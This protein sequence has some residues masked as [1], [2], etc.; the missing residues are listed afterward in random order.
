MSNVILEKLYRVEGDLKVLW[1][2]TE[3]GS[4]IFLQSGRSTHLI[5]RLKGRYPL[6]AI[7]LTQSLSDRSGVA[8]SLASVMAL[9][10]YLQLYPTEA[11]KKVRQILLDLSTI[12]SHIY[13]FYWELLP[14]YLNP[15][16]YEVLTE[17]ELWYYSGFHL[18]QTSDVDLSTD[19][20]VRL[21]RNINQAAQV[22]D[23]LQKC[24]ALLGGKFPVIM[25]QVPGGIANFS[26]PRDSGMK[27]LRNLERCKGFIENLWPEDIKLFLQNIPDATM[28]LEKEL[29]LISFGSL[30]AEKTRSKTSNYSE[31]ILL[32]GKLEPVNELKITESIDNTYYLPINGSGRKQ[33]DS[34]DFN[35]PLARTWIKGARYDGS[36]M[37]TGALSRMMITHL[38]GG[39]L[40]ISDKT[41]QMIDDLELTYEAPNCIASRILAQA[42][43]SRISLKNIF[44][45]LLD[46]DQPS[47]TN[48]RTYFDFSVEGVGIGKV[49]SPGGALMHQVFISDRKIERYR[50]ISPM[51]WNFSPADKSGETGIVETELNSLWQ[52][53]DLSPL[54]VARLLHSYYTQVL[55]GTL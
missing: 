45:N 35:K 27:V 44:R 21:V 14:D 8:H 15:D 30:I 17:E 26:I 11:A 31:G 12:R 13:H 5:S 41:G 1:S 52:T 51:N 29:N 22:L 34:Y 28:V 20:G 4:E 37:L 36:T 7:Q 25:N 24:I 48:R 19:T 9:E 43:E 55:D 53:R 10:D 40:E 42:I 39:N 32:G 46:L 18:K 6:E 38:A 2:Q 23:L 47:E 33:I 50:I 16:H 49:E 54:D 3:I